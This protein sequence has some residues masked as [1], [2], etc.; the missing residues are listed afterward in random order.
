MYKKRKKTNPRRIPATQ[1]DVKRAAE[2]GV[3]KAVRDTQTIFF[4]VLR[5]K[6]GYEIEDLQRFWE[7]VQKLSDEITEGYVSVSDLRH[8]LR[9]EAGIY[10]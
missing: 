10:I 8:T 2:T 7:K 1:A 3:A 5:D 4:T 6:E 9:E